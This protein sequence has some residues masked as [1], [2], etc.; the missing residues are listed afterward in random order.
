MTII[1]SLLF[2]LQLSVI[3]MAPAY[4]SQRFSLAITKATSKT[5]TDALLEVV[6]RK[7]TSSD[8]I[9]ALIDKGADVDA[10]DLFNNTPLIL[11]ASNGLANVCITLI[12]KGADVNA[13]SNYGN[14]PLTWAASNG[15][16][17]VCLTL[18]YKDADV[19][20]I[21][22][23]GWTPLIWAA[24]N[25]LRDVCITLIHKSADVN[26]KDNN[27]YTPL[28]FAAR[29]GLA[30]ICITLMDE[31]ADVNPRNEW[32][33]T[34][35]AGAVEKGLEDICILLLRHLLLKQLL[36][37]DPEGGNLS[38]RKTRMRCAILTLKKTTISKDLIPLIVRSEPLMHDYTACRYD[39]YC[40][41]PRFDE[42]HHAITRDQLCNLLG[43]G[44]IDALKA[45]MQQACDVC[46]GNNPALKNLLNPIAFDEHFDELFLKPL[47]P[48]LGE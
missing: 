27:D 17:D 38:A 40:C 13:T 2:I 11:A 6:K 32:G 4:A 33:N 30:D 18:I 15:L 16:R 47:K 29:N 12:D 36:T 21:D 46:D 14:T 42:Y 43:Q 26:A 5:A 34:P 25:G 28:T 9:N 24:G 20:A 48:T 37:A 8:D 39:T 22:Q 10:K 45:A 44:N 3:S 1:M 19:N 35:L 31:G 41:R 7:E 23:S